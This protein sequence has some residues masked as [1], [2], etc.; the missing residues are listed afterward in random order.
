MKWMKMS[1]VIKKKKNDSSRRFSLTPSI[2]AT[3]I[4]APTHRLIAR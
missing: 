2:V 4:D 3:R 1:K